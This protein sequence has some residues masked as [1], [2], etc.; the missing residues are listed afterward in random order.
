[1]TLQHSLVLVV[2][3]APALEQLM[4]KVADELSAD[5]E[6]QWPPGGIQRLPQVSHELDVL[7]EPRFKL[8][9]PS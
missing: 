6:N 4:C 7:I 5:V 3:K 8:D 9:A 2:V 1:M